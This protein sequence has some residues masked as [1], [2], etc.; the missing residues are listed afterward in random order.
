M[1]SS[2]DE[3][4][5]QPVLALYRRLLD[6]WNAHDASAYAAC[7]ADDGHAIGFDGS[8]MDGR[9]EIES[10]LR[11]IFADHVTGTYVAKVRGVRL[12]GADAAL[13]RAVAGMVPPGGTDVNPAVNALQTL[14][15]VRGAGEWRIALFQNTPAQFHGRSEAAAALTEELRAQLSR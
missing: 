10:S 1:S 9:T 3:T 12:L 5:E 4:Q 13:L 11:R 8:A 2:A 14:V 15:A 6:A 7:F